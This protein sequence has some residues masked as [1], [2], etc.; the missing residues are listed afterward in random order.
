MATARRCP[1]FLLRPMIFIRKPAISG[2]SGKTAVA[3]LSPRCRHAQSPTRSQIY[4]RGVKSGLKLST[5]DRLHGDFVLF[6]TALFDRTSG[7]AAVAPVTP[8]PRTAPPVM[9]LATR[10]CRQDRWD[11]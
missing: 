4:W 7:A 6:F 10:G 11:K 3:G 5:Q 1:P 2:S 9:L 8:S